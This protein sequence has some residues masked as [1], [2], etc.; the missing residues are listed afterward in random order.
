MRLTAVYVSITEFVA[1]K[2]PTNE[3]LRDERAYLH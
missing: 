1:N 2:K 3:A